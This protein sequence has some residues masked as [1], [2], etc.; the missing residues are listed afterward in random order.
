MFPFP[1]SFS[2]LKSLWNPHATCFKVKLEDFKTMKIHVS[3]MGWWVRA[4]LRI[5]A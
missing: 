5:V 3:S 1:S 2:K 4:E